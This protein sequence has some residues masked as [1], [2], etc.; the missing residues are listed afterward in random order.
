M[1]SSPCVGGEIEPSKTQ[2]AIDTGEGEVGSAAKTAEM[3]QKRERFSEPDLDTV[4]R[5]KVADDADH[6]D[7][8]EFRNALLLGEADFTFTRAFATMFDRPITAS[9]YGSAADLCSR[10][11]EDDE[12]KFTSSMASLAAIPNVS[13]VLAS[14]NCRILGQDVVPCQR[15]N[16]VSSK[17]QDCSFW[18]D[19]SDKFSLII[20]NFPHTDQNGKA[21]RL[22]RALFKQ[23]RICVD[24][25]RLPSDFT[26]EMRLREF[27]ERE[28]GWTKHRA[29]YCHEEAAAE[30]SFTPV[31]KYPDDLRRWQE[32]GYE[33]TMTKRDAKIR[34]LTG[35]VW[36]WRPSNNK[37]G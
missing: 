23:L 19:V 5:I 35:S 17:F 12:V 27:N 29:A 37:E 7:Y 24:D 13:N 15:F 11:H 34:G 16:S 26:L 36:R 22:V 32:L 8:D 1:S 9:E 21:S 6:V 28:G 31:G 33:H 30:S 2:P 3:T 20:F 25:G 14:L 18:P 10:Y 4:K